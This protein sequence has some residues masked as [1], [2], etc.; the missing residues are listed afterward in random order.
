MVATAPST[1]SVGH[2]GTMYPAEVLDRILFATRY[3]RLL[4][5]NG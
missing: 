5:K 4:D 3:T 2:K 1:F